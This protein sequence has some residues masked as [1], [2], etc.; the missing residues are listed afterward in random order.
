MKMFW[1]FLSL[2]CILSCFATGA[3]TSLVRQRLGNTKFYISIPSD[4]E[5]NRKEGLDF[6]VYYF[7]LTDTIS[8]GGFS[9]GLYFGS[10]PSSYKKACEECDVKTI[11]AKLLNK[12]C[13]WTIYSC[14]DSYYIETVI[15]KNDSDYV[16]LDEDVHGEGTI[17]LISENLIHAFGYA[18]KTND[19]DLILKI[20][21]TFEEGD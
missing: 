6:T 10:H 11:E 13:E 7:N 2:F 1:F 21:S 5:I 16:E 20:F 15:K 12:P 8:K 18:N 19:I 3:E 17:L 9:F 4:F 14:D